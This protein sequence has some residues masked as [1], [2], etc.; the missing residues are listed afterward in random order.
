MDI[1]NLLKKKDNTPHCSVVVVAAGS[2]ERMGSDKMLMELCGMPVIARTLTAFQQSPEVDDIIV[3]TRNDKIEMMAELCR[4]YGISKASQV[5]SGGATR[6]ES[7]L[8]GVSA[9]KCKAKLIAIHDGARPLVSAELIKRTV[10]A[11]AANMAAAPVLKSTDTLKAVD[12][13]GFIVATVDRAST[14]RVQT[15]QIFDADL[16][17]GALTKA[18]NDKMAITDDC[19]AVEMMGVKVCTVEGDTANIKLTT[20]DDMLIAEAILRDRGDNDAYRARV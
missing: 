8:A 4:K 1:M 5:I 17:K 10:S 18:V 16:I 2:S 13:N 11:A 15:P 20:P 3:V 9:V 12:Q 14:V 6:M 7:A 19:S